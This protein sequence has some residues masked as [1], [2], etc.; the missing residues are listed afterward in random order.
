MKKLLSVLCACLALTACEKDDANT[1]KIGAV[2]P[3]T[4]ANAPFGLDMRA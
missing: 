2:L 3:L 4:G 1:I